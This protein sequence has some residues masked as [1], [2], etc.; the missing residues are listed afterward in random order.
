MIVLFGLYLSVIFVIGVSMTIVDL[1]YYFTYNFSFLE[2][3]FLHHIL[4]Q[5][6]FSYKINTAGMI[7]IHSV[8]AAVT[9]PVVIINFIA[10]GVCTVG[11]N[12]W[13]WFCKTFAKEE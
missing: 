5:N 4:V 2:G 1:V 12:I 7:I 3:V 11:M 10:I 9:W 13:K 6:K 8:I